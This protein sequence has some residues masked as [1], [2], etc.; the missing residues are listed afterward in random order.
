M[1]NE[2]ETLSLCLFD[3]I[4]TDGTIVQRHRGRTNSLVPWFVISALAMQTKYA[5]GATFILQPIDIT[6]DRAP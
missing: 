5:V 3:S 2:P 4:S 1:E 6:I